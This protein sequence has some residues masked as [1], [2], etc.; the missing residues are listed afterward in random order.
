MQIQKV[1]LSPLTVLYSQSK[2]AKNSIGSNQSSMPYLTKFAYRDYGISFAGQINRSPANFY[3]FNKKNLPATMKEYLNEDYEDR[4]N[5]PPAQMM[6]LVYG[7]LNDIN[8]LDFV[9]RIFPDE[10]LFADLTDKPKRNARKGLVAEFE[11]LKD[12]MRDE[13]L[14]K[15]G[16]SNLGM[17]LLRKIYL[18]GKQ[19]KEINKDFYNDLSDTY[20]GLITSPVDYS[21]F[22]AYGIKFP[23]TPFWNSFVVTRDDWN[24]VYK[25]RKAFERSGMSQKRELSFDDIKK[26]DIQPKRPPKFKLNDYEV[27][28]MTDAIVDGSGSLDAAR[29][30]LKKKGIKDPEKLTFVSRYFGEIMSVALEKIHASDEMKDFFANYDSLNKKQREKFSAYWHNNN[31]MRALQSLAV[32]DTIKLFFEAYGA[33]GNNE[34][35]RDLLN[36]AASIKPEREAREAEHNRIQAEYDELFANFDLP[37]N[38]SQVEQVKQEPLSQEEIDRRLKEEA[39]KNGA[40]VIEFVSPEGDHYSCVCNIDEMFMSNLKAE[41][42]L[43]PSAFVNKYAKFMLSSPLATEP[44]KRSIALMV[45]VPDFA[46]K[47]LMQPDDYRK[48]SAE[49]NRDFGIKY[50]KYMLANEQALALRILDRLGNPAKYSMMIAFDAQKLM[51]F[52][53]DTVKIDDWTPEERARLNSDYKSFLEPITNK[54]EINQI[55]EDLVN[56]FKKVDLNAPRGEQDEFYDDLIKLT[57]ANMQKYP[58]VKGMLSKL[59]RQTKY[60]EEYGGSARLLLQD[61]V[62]ESVKDV[63]RRLMIE[64]FILRNSHDLIPIFALSSVNAK[65]YVHD[66]SLASMLVAKAVRLHGNFFN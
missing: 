48:I 18:E 17:Y 61:D 59:I 45:D 3:E 41:T 29:K 32:S 20:K 57:T 38:D 52:A 25:P 12:E 24:Y 39:L 53:A 26:A 55:N 44:Y 23:K 10:P 56:Y 9:P 30:N 14:F 65:K 63:K 40:E 2:P 54:R 51:N 7:D 4:Q 43:L 8:S 19:R 15:D 6:K 33:D 49:I 27:D 28:K 31:Q 11:T 50:S 5:M 13:P 64:D 21:T 47:L 36:Y 46:K 58:Q 66:E 37:Q 42:L 16:S 35:F 1:S 22:S 60:I 62:P 34:E